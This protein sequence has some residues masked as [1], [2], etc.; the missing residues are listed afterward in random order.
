[1]HAFRLGLCPLMML[2]FFAVDAGAGG[3]WSPPQVLS[4]GG[5]GWEAAGAT[6]GLGNSVAVW[7]ERTTSPDQVWSRSQPSGGSWGSVSQIFSPAV[8][9]NLLL[10]QVRISAAG[11]ATAI[12]LDNSGLWTADRPTSSQWSSPRLLSQ[13][14]S[15]GRNV[16]AE[17]SQEPTFKMNSGGEAAVVW[18]GGGSVVAVT[19]AAGGAWTSQQTVASP[20]SG[21]GASVDHAAI[22][23]NGTVI[24]IWDAFQIICVTRH[25]RQSCHNANFVLHASRRDPATGTWA[26]SG[27]LLGPDGSAHSS[28]VAL[29]STGR[30]ILV[31]LNTAGVYVSST[32]G[33][34]RGAWSA[35]ET[36]VS[37]GTIV[38]GTDLASDDAGDVTLVYESV[39]SASQAVAVRG[40]IAANAWA[41]PVVVSGAATSVGLVSL[42]LAPNGHALIDWVAGDSATPQVQAVFRATATGSWGSPIAVSGPGCSALGGSCSPEAIGVNSSG[43]GLVIYSG[44]DAAQVHTEYATDLQP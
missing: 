32:Q 13:D 34:P 8:E 43:N 7:I 1:M 39:S 41:P 29:D 28:R 5:Q 22:S 26:D 31:V 16:A 37:P 38:E 17:P 35:F 18:Q 9:T 30:A 25:S 2:M 3:T 12:W 23:A 42:A 21:T 33:A 20:G 11:F 15:L 19:R 36:A 24:A 44:Y 4:T 6:D 27:G 40:T 14:S 10:P